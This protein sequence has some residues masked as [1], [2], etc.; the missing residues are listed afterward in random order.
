MGSPAFFAVINTKLWMPLG[1]DIQRTA[2]NE[3]SDRQKMPTALLQGGLYIGMLWAVAREEFFPSLPIIQVSIG[4]YH[5]KI[6]SLFLFAETP[7][8]VFRVRCLL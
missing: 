4:K 5:R 6:K 7:H 3:Q 2:Q 1:R 8:S